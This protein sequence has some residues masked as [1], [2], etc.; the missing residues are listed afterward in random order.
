[1]F[2][3]N[4]PIRVARP[5]LPSTNYLKHY[6]EMIDEN[7][8]YSNFGPLVKKFEKN[9]STEL[10]FKS[11]GV[12]SS[13]SS[14]TAALELII[15]QFQFPSRSNVLVPSFTFI[16]TAQAIVNAGLKPIFVD[17]DRVS[18]ALKPE[19]AVAYINNLNLNIKAIIAVAPF[20]S[21]IKM[22]EWEHFQRKT[23]IQVIIDAAACCLKNVPVSNIVPVMVSTHATKVLPSGEGG[24]VIMDDSTRL[25]EI[26][27]QSNFGITDSGVFNHGTNCKLSEYHAAIG[28]ASIEM[29]EST[30]KELHYRC[31]LYRELLKDVDEISFLPGFGK[32]WFNITCMINGPVGLGEHLLKAGIE[33]R[34][35][36][37]TGCHREPF[38]FKKNQNFSVSETIAET[39]L[40]LPMYVDLEPDKIHFICEHVKNFCSQKSKP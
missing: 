23:G 16:A 14:G 13:A 38:F 3:Q 7:R 1:M 30:S 11:K 33:T 26:S 21:P 36:W 6:F 9:I 19:K 25:A 28:L 17:V 15:R 31:S 32:S 27:A 37:K 24:L 20:G 22:D 5:K 8:H 35:W 40:G 18:W 34:K 39:Y 29:W 10:G 4:A 2:N 12:V